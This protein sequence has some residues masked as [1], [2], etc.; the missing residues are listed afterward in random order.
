MEKILDKLKY[1]LL[2][3]QHSCVFGNEETYFYSDLKGIRPLMQYIQ[4]GKKGYYVADKI[5][6]KAA[7][8]LFILLEVKAVYADTISVEGLKTLEDN[9]IPVFY[10]QLVDYIIN[11][12]GDDICP[13]EKTVKDI[14]DPKIAYQAL[15][16]KIKQM[17][18]ISGENNKQWK[19]IWVFSPR[20]K[21]KKQDNLTY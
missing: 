20:I 2:A 14:D 6:G 9:N 4:E 12:T 21:V 16:E 7:A 13:M 8:Y 10:H 17:Q 18:T 15:I 3:Q 1:I 5:V 19:I 11:R